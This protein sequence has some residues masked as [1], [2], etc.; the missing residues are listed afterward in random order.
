MKP[1]ERPYLLLPALLRPQ[2]RGC[3]VG[4]QPQA[5]L[6]PFLLVTLPPDQHIVVR[7]RIHHAEITETQRPKRVPVPP[8]ALQGL[9][10]T[11][12]SWGAS[13]HVTEIISD[14][15]PAP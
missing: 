12:G 4:R 1:I 2:L 11:G 5:T 8:S 3:R 7:F 9:G 6:F 10:F 15:R 14:A 13:V